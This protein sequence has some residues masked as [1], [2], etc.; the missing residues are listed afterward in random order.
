[1]EV[2]GGSPEKKTPPGM[3]RPWSLHFSLC[4]Q[5]TLQRFSALG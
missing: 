5:K 3:R 4:R 1:V 2:P